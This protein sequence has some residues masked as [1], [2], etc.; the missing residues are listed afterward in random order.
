MKHNGG[1][2]VFGT[3]SMS[4]MADCF[5][6]V[7]HGF[8][9]SIV[10][11][12]VEVGENVVLMSP[13]QPSKISHRFQSRMGGPPEPLAQKLRCPSSALISPDLTESL[14][15]QIGPV[16]SQVHLLQKAQTLFLLRRQVPR[17]LQPDVSGSRK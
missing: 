2:P 8:N 14:F 13:Q 5:S 17:V 1:E 7:V 11:R 10:N 16:D 3:K 12:A 15:E 4:A 9:G 6:V